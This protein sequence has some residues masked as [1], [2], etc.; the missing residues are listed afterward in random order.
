VGVS[1]AIQLNFENEKEKK[2]NEGFYIA[3]DETR[4]DG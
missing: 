3:R 2:I 4:R 1:S